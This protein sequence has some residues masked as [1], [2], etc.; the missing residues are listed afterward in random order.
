MLSS[1]KKIYGYI[2]TEYIK[3]MG[4]PKRLLKVKKDI[5]SGKVDSLKYEIPK[6][7]IFIDR[8]GTINKEVEHLSEIEQFELIDGAAEALSFN[9]IN[10]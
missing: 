5:I 6:I 4:T 2:S 3:D 1:E 9:S 8:D 7:A 10:S